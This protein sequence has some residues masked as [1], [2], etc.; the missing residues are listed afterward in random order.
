MRPTALLLALCCAVP[1]PAR[2]GPDAA[3]CVDQVDRLT[4]RFP[5]NAEGE[6]AR[7][8]A[9]AAGSRQGASLS[10]EQRRAIGSR[11]EAAR[12]AGERGDGEACLTNLAEVRAALREAGVGGVQPGMAGST[13]VMGSP[14]GAGS[15]APGISRDPLTG[16]NRPGTAGGAGS[17]TGGTRPS[18][19]GG[20][21]GG[22][23]SGGGSSGG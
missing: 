14:G 18:G 3:A 12:A 8:L 23:S 16:P 10:Q 20:A 7:S 19:S 6:Q 21:G 13:D 5:V 22:G 17:L 4:E 1:A 15:G 9:G 11:I 2:A